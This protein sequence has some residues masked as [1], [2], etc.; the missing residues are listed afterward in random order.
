[1]LSLAIMVGNLWFISFP[2]FLGAKLHFRPR[3]RTN[4]GESEVDNLMPRLDHS[5]KLQSYHRMEAING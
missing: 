5:F 4:F 2:H 1:M 3:R